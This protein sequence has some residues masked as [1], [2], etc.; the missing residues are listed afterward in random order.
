MRNQNRIGKERKQTKSQAQSPRTKKRGIGQ[1]E[2]VI[3][4]ITE[5]QYSALSASRVFTGFRRELWWNEILDTAIQ[6]SLVMSFE[7]KSPPFSILLIVPAEQWAVRLAGIKNVRV[8]AVEPH[9]ASAR[10][11]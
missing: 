4:K 9:R 7:K 10:K 11:K 8:L 6:C 2:A 1:Q 5:A 3:V